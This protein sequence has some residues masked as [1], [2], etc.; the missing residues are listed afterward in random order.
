MSYSKNNKKYAYKNTF[1]KKEQP[2]MAEPIEQEKI[3]EQVPSIITQTFKTTSRLNM[4]EGAGMDKKII[5]VIPRGDEVEYYG[6]SIGDWYYV[7]YKEYTGFCL[8][9]WLQ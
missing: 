5:T 2:I 9:N 8:K 7:K 6:Y 3:Q 1:V 4:R